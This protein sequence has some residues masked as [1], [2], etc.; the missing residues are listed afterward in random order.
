MLILSV[1]LRTL[2]ETSKVTKTQKYRDAQGQSDAH[3]GSPDTRVSADSRRVNTVLGIPALFIK[4]QN[5]QE[6]KGTR[7]NCE[8]RETFAAPNQT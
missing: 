6:N 5:D 3:P 8:R 2:T 7:H 1:S 4:Q